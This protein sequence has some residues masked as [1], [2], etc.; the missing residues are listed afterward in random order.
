MALDSRIAYFD[1]QFRE[2]KLSEPD[3]AMRLKQTYDVSASHLN[4]D[5]INYIESLLNKYQIPLTSRDPKNK[6]SEKITDG[7]AAQFI[8]GIM[9][10]FTTFGFAD[11]P[12][13]GAERILNSLGHLIGLAPDMIALATAS[14]TGGTSVVAAGLKR[15]A[16][17]SGSKRLIAMAKSLEKTAEKGKGVSQLMT[18]RLGRLAE[19]TQL[20]R[21][22]LRGSKMTMVD[23]ATGQ[24]LFGLKSLPGK[25][26]EIIQ[27]NST[28]FLRR[29]K[30]R[31]VKMF[32]EGVL[33][34]LKI[35]QSRLDN[36]VGSSVHLGLLLAGSAQ[37]WGTRGRGWKGMAEA[38]VHG[39]IAGGVFA[40]IGEYVNIARMVNSTNPAVAKLGDSIIRRTAQGVASPKNSNM[41]EQYDLIN[42]FMRGTAGA[43][44]GKTMASLNDLPI[45]EEIYEIL[46]SS[47]FSINSR[48][49]WENRARRDIVSNFKIIPR[50]MSMKDARLWLKEKPWYQ[51][52]EKEYQWYWDKYLNEIKKQQMNTIVN[53]IPDLQLAFIDQYE[54]LRK[55]GTITDA[56]VEDAKTNRKTNIEILKLITDA[57]ARVDKIDSEEHQSK[58]G[59]VNNRSK[60]DD[61]PI[62]KDVP[63]TIKLSTIDL[64][65]LGDIEV[66]RSNNQPM[67]E[68]IPRYEALRD[69]ARRGKIPVQRIH[70]EFQRVLDEVNYDVDKF[71]QKI[72]TKK[73][74]IAK[75]DIRLKKK[76]KRELR[77][78]AESLKHLARTQN[79]T[80]YLVGNDFQIDTTPLL[81]FYDRPMGGRSSKDR[82]D[83]M[84]AVVGKR[85]RDPIDY[86]TTK[87][88]SRVYDPKSNKFIYPELIKNIAPLDVDLFSTESSLIKA[89]HLSKENLQ[90]VIK[91]LNDNQDMFVY[92]AISDTGKLDVRSYPW[93]KNEKD[94]NYLS[95]LEL[96]HVSEQ[97]MKQDIKLGRKENYKNQIATYVWRLRELRLIPDFQNLTTNRLVDLIGPWKLVESTHGYKDI[98]TMQKR[99]KLGQGMEIPYDPEYFM[100]LI[101][102]P[103]DAFEFRAVPPGVRKAKF[104]NQ[105]RKIQWSPPDDIFQIDTKAPT[106]LGK[107]FSAF[108]AKIRLDSGEIIPIETAW[109]RMKGYKTWREGKGKKDIHG[110]SNKQMY[111][112][113]LQLWEKWADQNP[114]LIEALGEHLSQ[115]K[116]RL[117]D[118]FAKTP[119]NQAAALT[120]ILNKRY[121]KGGQFRHVI[122]EDL[123]SSI[124]DM[125]EAMKKSNTGTD[126]AEIERQDIFDRG[127]EKYGQDPLTG[128]RKTVGYY[129]PSG[130]GKFSR[131]LT[132][133]KKATFRADD[134]DNA[135]MVKHGIHR[136]VY[137]SAVKTGGLTFFGHRKSKGKNVSP[138]KY[139]VAE[140]RW[141]IVDKDGNERGDNYLKDYMFTSRIE[142]SYINLGVYE[143]FNED[144]IKILQQALMNAN[145]IEMDPNTPVGK[146]FWNKWES[147]MTEV[148]VGSEA[149]NKKVDQLLKENKGLGRISI[150]DLSLNKIGEILGKY[151]GSKLA[152]D[153]V[154]QFMNARAKSTDDIKFEQEWEEYRAKE[155]DSQVLADLLAE[156]GFKHV[157]WLRPGNIDF[158]KRS[159]LNYAVKRLTRPFMQDSYVAKL[160]LYDAKISQ[161][162]QKYSSRDKGLANDEFMLY[163]GARNDWRI[164]VKDYN[165]NK[166]ITLGEFWDRW[167]VLRTHMEKKYKSLPKKGRKEAFE[168]YKKRSKLWKEYEVYEGI[169]NDIPFAR[170]PMLVNSG[171]RTGTFVGFVKGRRGVSLVTNEYNDNMLGGADKDIDA[172]HVYLGMPKEIAKAYSQEH[173]RY[174]F[175]K[176]NLAPLKSDEVGERIAGAE[177]FNL[178]KNEGLSSILD[179]DYKLTT[180]TTGTLS[181]KAIGLLSSQILQ[182]KLNYDLTKQKIERKE[183]AP[184]DSPFRMIDEKGVVIKVLN[185]P[186]TI[187]E[188]L[189]DYKE[190][191]IM[192]ANVSN[193]YIDAPELSKINLPLK[194]LRN[195]INEFIDPNLMDK[196]KV[197][198]EFHRSLFGHKY[199]NEIVDINQLSKE[200]L[201]EHEGSLSYLNLIAKQLQD[202]NF[203]I[204]PW[205]K[206]PKENVMSLLK[207]LDKVLQ[208][209][210]L[211]KDLG[212]KEFSE[213][214]MKELTTKELENIEGFDPFLWNKINAVIDTTIA[215]KYSER[216]IDYAMKEL[217]MNYTDSRQFVNTVMQT[218]FH[219]RH[220]TYESRRRGMNTHKLTSARD[221]DQKEV[222]I[223]SWGEQ[224]IRSKN[225]L[226]EELTHLSNRRAVELRRPLSSKDKQMFRDLFDYWYQATPIVTFPNDIIDMNNRVRLVQKWNEN[227]N[228]LKATKKQIE[229]LPADA[230]KFNKIS[231][232]KQLL[233]IN[234]DLGLLYRQRGGL[235]ADVLG[236]IPNTD[237]T[238]A[239]SGRVKNEIVDLKTQLFDS[240]ARQ[241]SKQKEIIERLFDFEREEFPDHEAKDDVVTLPGDKIGP[242]LIKMKRLVPQ[243]VPIENLEDKDWVRKKK[244]EL[245][246]ELGPINTEE[247]KKEIK[248]FQDLLHMNAI[249]G[250]DFVVFSVADHYSLLL[251]QLNVGK[252]ELIAETIN[253]PRLRFFNNMLENR[254]G[255][256][257]NFFERLKRSKSLVKEY[258]PLFDFDVYDIDA[259]SFKVKVKES[260][261]LDKKYD[262][263]D[264]LMKEFEKIQTE[265]KKE[266]HAWANKAKSKDIIHK[267]SKDSKDKALFTSD[268][269]YYN[270]ARKD[271]KYFLNPRKSKLDPEFVVSDLYEIKFGKAQMLTE[272]M[273][274]QLG[275]KPP[276]KSPTGLHHMMFPPQQVKR[277]APFEKKFKLD[278]VVIQN[279]KGELEEYGVIVPTA[280]IESNAKLVGDF[281]NYA[282]QLM[283]TNEYF[284]GALKSLLNTNSRQYKKHSITLW[285]AAVYKIQWNEG[286]GPRIDEAKESMDEIK[287]GYEKSQEKLKEIKE[288]FFI[289]DRKGEK[290]RVSATQMV[291]LMIGTKPI[292]NAKGDM[293]KRGTGIVL[294]LMDKVEQDYIKSNYKRIQKMAGKSFKVYYKPT[295]FVNDEH[296]KY[297]QQQNSRLF[298]DK[299][300]LIMPSRLILFDKI[301]RSKHKLTVGDKVVR[302]HFH[303]NDIKW[304]HFQLNI[305]EYMVDKY[306]DSSGRID[307][308][309]YKNISS[310]T[311]EKLTKK[312]KAK[313]LESQ[314]HKII[315]E[316]EGYKRDY[317][318]LEEAA[319]IGHIRAFWPLLQE[320]TRGQRKRILKEYL[321]QE[322]ERIKKATTPE[323]LGNIYLE[324]DVNEGWKT[325]ES[326]KQELIELTKMKLEGMSKYENPHLN[327]E[328]E[329]QLLNM[330]STRRE[331]PFVAG[332]GS[333][334]HLKSRSKIPVP[335]YR[336]DENVPLEYA[337]K[338]S[339]GWSQGVAA[340]Y[341]R[342]NIR[343]F[344][345][346]GRNNPQ[347]KDHWENWQYFM[348]D[349]LK[350]FMNY[351]S[352][353]SIELHGLKES[354]V[355]FLKKWAKVNFDD[356]KRP[357]GDI[358]QKKLISDFYNYATPSLEAQAKRKGELKAVMHHYFV[359]KDNKVLDFRRDS[360]NRILNDALADAHSKGKTVK[361]LYAEKLAQRTISFNKWMDAERKKNMRKELESGNIDKIAYYKSMKGVYGDEAVGNFMLRMEQRTN[362]MLGKLPGDM[363]IWKSLPENPTARHRA[364]VERIQWISDLEGKFE[365]ISLLSHPKSGMANMIGGTANTIVDTGWTHIRGAYSPKL[366]L[367]EVFKNKTYLKFD[368]TTKT[369]KKHPI[370][371]MEDVYDWVESLGVI[372]SNIQQELVLLKAQGPTE[373]GHFLDAVNKKMVRYIKKH[374]LP[375]D[376]KSRKNHEDYKDAT[377]GELAKKHRVSKKFVDWGSTVMSVTERHLRVRSFL[378]HYLKA[379]DI[380]ADSQ[381]NIELTEDFIVEYAKKG[382]A[383]S[384]FIYHATNRP[385]F[386]NTAFGRIMTRFHP[387]GWNSVRR[388]YHII[389]DNL[390]SEGFAS[391]KD[392]GFEANKRFQRQIQMDLFTSALSLTFAYSIF[393]YALSPPMNWFIDF[394]QLLFGDEKTR[395]RAFFSQWPN[396]WMAPLSIITPPSGRFI[397]PHINGMINGDWEAFSKYTFATYF[398]FGR[399][400]RD[401]IRTTSRP[402]MIAEYMGGVPIHQIGRHI[403]R[404][405]KFAEEHYNQEGRDLFPDFI[406]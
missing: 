295:T 168:K 395:E 26:A 157:A 227:F 323:E 223:Y 9:E 70:V 110:W 237:R 122:L 390:I 7:L 313:G 30:I 160:G 92:G 83:K 97:L 355:T 8:S 270:I 99:L 126:G 102:K 90:K 80:I 302:N 56:M 66:H 248:R 293:V 389:Q 209:S 350:S 205:A 36:I 177:R 282:N 311:G 337:N 406:S 294:P 46:L 181:R 197:I 329:Q 208:D 151:P 244:I 76:E 183:I 299:Q 340:L 366:L 200:F 191:T 93:S 231:K 170:S 304:I 169:R 65:E 148:A 333:H 109:Q 50:T 365:M 175:G 20:G 105:G 17:K 34:S 193:T 280:T 15:H 236:R 69:I 255:K 402:E 327:A 53:I 143:K 114:A 345:I 367:G 221:K 369:Y 385:G 241:A 328:V 379:R 321:P 252:G 206:Y 91:D 264:A 89:R 262:N 353:R 164:L 47:F 140:E 63:K 372:E 35:S 240:L 64:G 346:K 332:T 167:V 173:I 121:W 224:I 354:D 134:I 147:M 199:K 370:K 267:L 184:K 136:M 187:Q 14:I 273:E 86:L 21:F 263:M 352:T 49:A 339:R 351:P 113:Y 334:G 106:K 1:K 274:I 152:E 123:P 71:I 242:A 124:Q 10:G 272:A 52:E 256:Q 318:E 182:T 296:P 4:H 127:T 55:D 79:Q 326:A 60:K 243:L 285:D 38:G 235:E 325:L 44:Y 178:T 245:K 275:I 104:D 166:R 269:L 216:F 172:A 397:L 239:I 261:I 383:A 58:S 138:I 39:A 188:Y 120:D 190:L 249:K 112:K 316:I 203:E 233:K 111:S 189:K 202:V 185:R 78:V 298:M 238:W 119:Q 254:Y 364:M 341:A 360:K 228:K 257:G 137:K 357:G 251:G 19:K 358:I 398:P 246:K 88:K 45:E 194:T 288:D 195:F 141:M 116:L 308:T 133:E 305:R 310:E 403:R 359:I 259:P 220:R 330:Q 13:T 306:G 51:K 287:I 229:N 25:A 108:N 158:V 381:G 165:D 118:T 75:R 156:V 128:V 356:D 130:S 125:G 57:A 101:E 82:I 81:D 48:P 212:I 196:Q 405:N 129:R 301:V 234:E 271:K 74:G 297:W 62:E 132:V 31:P 186:P 163:E 260:G 214:F 40:S 312:E 386:S 213:L 347:M 16:M 155:H 344:A 399:V 84:F 225:M 61:A 232:H 391:T 219:Q 135:F 371:T 378:A 374:G 363:T 85:L 159:W 277:L 319:E 11:E 373:W 348:L 253:L 73:G 179:I 393:E 394:S 276:L 87:I 265:Y 32:N 388:R 42:T 29:A 309:Y 258:G 317:R 324:R 174:Q 3:L 284:V 18:L 290:K 96:R 59:P 375:N 222:P 278:R 320:Q 396:Q 382:V 314:Y 266:F 401:M 5:S 361:E 207:S 331:R 201:S 368:P 215:A 43:A 176:E 77:Q 142:D 322:I 286:K 230:K 22:G 335:G 28:A 180:G 153:I 131:P 292:Y 2:G 144:R 247:L 72:T 289:I 68:D 24:P 279:R 281:H 217:D 139:N 336:T 33:G 117:F 300:G 400:T 146:A 27:E 100:D 384:Q 362:R 218:I 98:S 380:F 211:A 171:M 103:K 54:K 149:S 404:R 162:K 12:D 145:T 343:N 387:Y 315:D 192:N 210:N 392:M 342:I 198:K 250:N 349:Q 161:R 303:E 338:I 377:I 41:R 268:P 226:E 37:P 23:P 94:S 95:D 107:M 376:K 291:D 115:N 6:T 204:S 154:K 67:S 150:D 307:W 283:S